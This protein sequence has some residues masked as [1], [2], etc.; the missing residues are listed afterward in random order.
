MVVGLDILERNFRC[1]LGE[2][3]II[4]RDKQCVVF[5][6][7]RSRGPSRFGVAAASVTPAKQRK[8]ARAAGLYLQRKGWS[9]SVTCRFDVIAFDTGA[10]GERDHVQ[11]LRNAFTT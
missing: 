10:A 3:D 5:V 8:L 7:V 1:K 11:W 4:A 6:E 9:S 2:I